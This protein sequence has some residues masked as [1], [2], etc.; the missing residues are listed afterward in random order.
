MVS[1]MRVIPVAFGMM[2]AENVSTGLRNSA[3]TSTNRN[4]SAVMN[5]SALTVVVQAKVY[6]R[7]GTSAF[8]QFCCTEP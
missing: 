4:T 8:Q 3:E 2:W 1:L 7:S 6:G 5:A